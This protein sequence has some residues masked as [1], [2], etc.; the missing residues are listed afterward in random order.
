MFLLW[1]LLYFVEPIN[2]VL[3]LILHYEIYN[4]QGVEH[5]LV[6][7]ISRMYQ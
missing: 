1:K 7:Y 4:L 5:S 6:I 2:K 3:I